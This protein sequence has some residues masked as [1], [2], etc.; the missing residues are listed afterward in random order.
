VAVGRFCHFNGCLRGEVQF[1]TGGQKNRRL[2]HDRRAVARQAGGFD[3]SFRLFDSQPPVAAY[4][5]C[6]SKSQVCFGSFDWVIDTG[7]EFRTSLGRP[8]AATALTTCLAKCDRFCSDRS[9][10]TS[11]SRRSPARA[12]SLATSRILDD[13]SRCEATS[14]FGSCGSAVVVRLYGRGLAGELVRK[15]LPRVDAEAEVRRQYSVL[16]FEGDIGS[17]KT[18][19]LKV[20]EA[21]F[22]TKLPYAYIDLKIFEDERGFGCTAIAGRVSFSACRILRTVWHTPLSQTGVGSRHTACR[23]ISTRECIVAG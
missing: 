23:A 9:S 22:D 19:L 13:P 6:V 11:A 10:R 8:A 16:L 15:S 1:V 7:C 17:G 12:K 18:I 4:A 20:L 2:C 5:V 21:Q 3:S 14:F